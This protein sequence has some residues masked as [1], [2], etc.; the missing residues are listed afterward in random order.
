MHA[1]PAVTNDALLQLEPLPGG[2]TRASTVRGSVDYGFVRPNVVVGR[3]AGTPEEPLYLPVT[4]AM[5]EQLGHERALH[6]FADLENIEG[7]EPALRERWVAWFRAHRPAIASCHILFR[8]R[9]VAIGI[10]IIGVAIGG[11][12]HTYGSRD[13][14]EAALLRAGL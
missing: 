5:A 7:Y 9:L 1:S 3:Y 13:E 12:V 14:F 2:M 8:S 4:Q 6:V 11:R 10:G